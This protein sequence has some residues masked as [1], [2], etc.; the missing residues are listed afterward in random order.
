MSA[1]L[2]KAGAGEKDVRLRTC[3][4]VRRRKKKVVQCE[5]AHIVRAAPA[6]SSTA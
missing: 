5:L 2:W 4:P 1:K 6:Q 3:R